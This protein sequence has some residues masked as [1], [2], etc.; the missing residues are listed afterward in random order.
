MQQLLIEIIPIAIFAVAVGTISSMVGIGGG[1]INTPLLIIVFAL[2]EQQAP[3]TALVAAL[4]VAVASTAAYARQKPRPIVLKAGLFLAL[5]TIPGSLVGVALRELITEDYVLRLI[6]GIS[7][8]PVAIKMLFARKRGE[9]D[10]VALFDFGDITRGRL[11]LS[12]FGGFIGGAAAGLLGIGGGAVV[13]PVFTILMGLPIHAAVAT[14]MFTMIFTASAGTA[15]NYIGGHIDPVLAIAL[16]IGMIVGAQIGARLACRVN[17]VELKRIFG[18]VLVFPLVKMMKLGQIWLDP[19]DTNFLLATVGDVIIWLA[20]VVPV[21]I[22]RFFLIAREQKG[23]VSD[24]CESPTP[25]V[26]G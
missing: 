26:S 13:V 24:E 15:R 4:F 25:G 20:I 21:G 23:L 3:A 10:D 2:T 7:L 17:A 6:F 18:L 5:T 12:L 16:G 11:G 8:F 14:S 9:A 1:I 19:L 22:I